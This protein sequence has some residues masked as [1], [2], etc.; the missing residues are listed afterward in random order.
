MDTQGSLDEKIDRLTSM[1]SKLTAQDDNQ[2]KQFKPMIYQNKRRGQM[3]H[4]YDQNY[5]QRNYQNRYRSKNS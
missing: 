2:S 1:M 3:R 5:G 4:F